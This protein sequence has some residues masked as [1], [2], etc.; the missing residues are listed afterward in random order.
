MAAL[1]A[2]DPLNRSLAAKVLQLSIRKPSLAEY[3]LGVPAQVGV[4]GRF[5]VS[6]QAGGRITGDSEQKRGGDARARTEVKH[7][8]RAIA[9]E[10]PRDNR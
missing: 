4:A 6:D 8:R 10:S 1:T 5:R 7:G 9:H 2:F 3:G